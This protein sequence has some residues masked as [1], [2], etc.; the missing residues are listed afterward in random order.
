MSQ[1]EIYYFSGTG[2]SFFVAKE[3]QKLIPESTLIP[4]VN[5][6]KQEIIETKAEVIG[7]VFPSH[8]MIMPIPIKKFIEK[9][10]IKS[11]K[12]IFAIVTR[13][14]TEFRGFNK[15]E[16]VLKK[17]GKHLD[18]YFFL[19]MHNNDPKFK[20]FKV[21]TSENTTRMEQE[22][23]NRLEEI[24]KIINA[25]ATN[26]E[27]DINPPDS[28]SRHFPPGIAQIMEWFVIS[29]MKSC[30]NESPRDYFYVDT[31]CTG[32]GICEKVCLSQK[33][34]MVNKQPTWQEPI[35]CFMCYTCLNY[36]PAQAIQINSK[37]YM[38]SYTAIT[39]RYPHPGATIKEIAAQK[40]GNII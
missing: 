2:N 5:L 8:G 23:R 26:K 9:A 38:K 6:L 19:S 22:I 30:E 3:L 34:K 14:G 21:P 29:A 17:K 13:G 11:C 12:Y 37:W 15:L 27:K 35:I 40:T 1:A 10:D 32:C 33:V 25:R 39:G 18:A 31:K 16:S 24:Q 20:E 36:C 28:F 4:V 7:L